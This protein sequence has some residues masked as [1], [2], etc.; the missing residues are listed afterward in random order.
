MSFTSY[1]VPTLDQ[2]HEVNAIGVDPRHPRDIFHYSTGS[3][4]Y[5][6][7]HKGRNVYPSIR[8]QLSNSNDG[9]EA[10]Y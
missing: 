3:I 5:E 1:G 8:I 2:F 9:S 7:T 10:S 4:N 6:N